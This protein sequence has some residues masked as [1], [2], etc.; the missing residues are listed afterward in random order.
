[1]PLLI[2]ADPPVTDAQAARQSGKLIV[3]AM[4]N[5]HAGEVDGKEALLGLARDLAIPM[6]SPLLKDLVVLIAPNVNPDGAAQVSAKNRP[7]QNGPKDGVGTRQNGG[8]LDLNRDFVKLDTPE[9]RALVRFWTLWDPAI[10]I[11]THTTNGSR[12]RYALTYDGPRHPATAPPVLTFTRDAF[13]PEIARR[14]ESATGRSSF[15][16]GNFNCARDRWDSYPAL[17]RLGTQYIGLRNR[18]AVLTES[19]V[20]DPFRERVRATRAFIQQTLAV[21]AAKRPQIVELLRRIDREAETSPSDS[22]NAA[23]S[24]PLK[25][26]PVPL[27]STTTILGFVEQPQGGK[28]TAAETPKEYPVVYFG[29]CEPTQSARLPHGYL[30]DATHGAAVVET[31]QRHGIEV[32]SLVEDIELDVE[33]YAIRT[34][35]HDPSSYEGRNRLAVEVES[36]VAKR[37]A[38]AGTFLVNTAQRLGMLAA[39]LL[40]PQ[41]DDGLCSWGMFPSGLAAGADYPITRL[42]SQ[43]PIARDEV[44][45]LPENRAT[46][47]PITFDTLYG[48]R[49]RTNLF[50]SPGGGQTWLDDGKHYL[51]TK[52]GRLH[53]VEAG[54][55]RAKPFHDVNAMSKS[56]EIAGI[57]GKAA[58]QLA[59]ANRFT[60][61]P[62]RSAAL[63]EH[64]GELFHATF[65]GTAAVQLTR[66]PKREELAQYSPDGRFVAFVREHNL[67]VVDVATQTER[68]LTV[69]GN[70]LISNGKA[71]WV[72][73]EEIYNRNWNA[74]WWSPDS[75]RIV[76]LQFD[77]RPLQTFSVVNPI[78]VHQTIE[79]TPYPKAG[80]PNPIVRVGAVSAS[81]GPVVWVNLSDYD[82]PSFLVTRV[83]WLPDSKGVYLDV[84]DRA[85]TRLDLL[86]SAV[87]GKQPKR[88]FRE[89]TKAWVDDPGPPWFLADGSFVLPSDRTGWRHL[90]HYDAGGRLLHT[91]T[92]GVW[93]VR[94]IHR[95]DADA[96][97]IYFSATRD[98]PCAENLYRASVTG[99]SLER[100]TREAGNHRINL[101]PKGDLV[102]VTTSDLAT[103]PKS[104]LYRTDGTLLRTIHSSPVHALDEY[105]HS[106]IERVEIRTP[107]GFTLHGTLLKP[108]GFDAKR[109]YPAW[110]MTYAGPHAPSVTDGWSFRWAHDQMLAQLGMVVFRCDPRS[111]SGKGACSTWTAYRQLGVQELKD[112]EAAIAWLTAHPF[113]DPGR[114]GMSGHS[115]GGF[116]TAYAMTHSKLFAAGIAGAPVTD[117]RN[118]DSIYTE[119]Y[120]D[121]PQKNREGYDK[122]SVVKAAP[123]LHGRLLLI[124]GLVDD[125]VHVQNTMQLVREL[126][127][128][129]KDFELMVYPEHRHGI[130]GRHY[131]R[132]M[133]DFIR[134]TMRPEP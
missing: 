47:R 74:F 109:K 35:T 18:I 95:L 36:R 133:I 118:Y 90:Y 33:I 132:L 125:N 121:T 112:I 61:N 9:V 10:I 59:S 100:I 56:L 31:L 84:Q 43:Q 63:L 120:M 3:F 58:R 55:G 28:T 108:P 41:S 54:T 11:D 79:S 46:R 44:R 80:D 115:Y 8:G 51:Q 117:W 45:P 94:D 106:P 1:M 89:T 60:M 99:G 104:R 78:P 20:Y 101:S 96:G 17:P 128:A 129:D 48:S 123:N 16:Y 30:I 71:D 83:G 62:K 75:S 23:R 65:D 25:C 15:F 39:Y 134:R 40:E 73:F 82:E 103:P 126:Q 114:I 27:G 86:F 113:I 102:I 7:H 81:G 37:M 32:S 97:W 70:K 98:A 91:V 107:D 12:H 52:D 88:L 49:G 42:A 66:D 24:V 53:V 19:Y 6:P 130:D 67:Y 76:F 26:K 5:I 72:Y 77:D 69:D 124:H 93:E 21:A 4:G 34:A 14:T 50:G 85:Q 13:L 111:A 116:M 131:Q 38:K 2:V 110:F 57:D 22:P 119:R 64:N 29:A 68:A 105:T 127:R 87:D 92:Q 122:S